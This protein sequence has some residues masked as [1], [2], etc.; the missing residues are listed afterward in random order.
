[1]TKLTVTIDLDMDAYRAKYGPGS[2][3]WTEFRTTQKKVGEEWVRT[4]LPASEY[5]YDKNPNLLPE[6]IHEALTEAFYDWHC[7]GWM[8]INGEPTREAQEAKP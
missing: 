2:E 1:M 5:E 7:K 8:K 6:I 4:P 3:W